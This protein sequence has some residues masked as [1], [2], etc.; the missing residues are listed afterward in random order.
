MAM[1][2]K[3]SQAAA[4][5]SPPANLVLHLSAGEVS[6]RALEGAQ[7][8]YLHENKEHSGARCGGQRFSIGWVLNAGA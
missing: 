8:R 2:S 6:L 4:A 3:Q 5:L 7:R 1:I